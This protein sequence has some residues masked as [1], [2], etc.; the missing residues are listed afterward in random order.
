MKKIDCLCCLLLVLG[1]LNWGLIGF[2]NFNLLDYFIRETWILRVLYVFIGFA[3]AYHAVAWK[4]V[5][6][7]NK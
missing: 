2:F 6:K 5:H 7:R 3:A 4:T 1:G